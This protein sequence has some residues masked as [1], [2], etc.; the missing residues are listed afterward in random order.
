M[1]LCNNACHDGKR[2]EH[3]LRNTPAAAART[4]QLLKLP[5]LCCTSKGTDSGRVTGEMT[6]KWNRLLE[7]GQIDTAIPAQD[8]CLKSELRTGET[9]TA[10]T[11]THTHTPDPALF[12]M[13]A[14]SR[15]YKVVQI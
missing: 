4:E 14:T 2:R 5:L 8:T 3:P 9:E 11:H 10:H 1:F 15:K 12:D 6:V 13:F 7:A